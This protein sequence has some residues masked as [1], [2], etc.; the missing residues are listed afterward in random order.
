VLS[1]RPEL[2]GIGGRNVAAF[3]RDA[4][5]HDKHSRMTVFEFGRSFGHPG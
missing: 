2:C 1:T 5:I 3:K 4:R